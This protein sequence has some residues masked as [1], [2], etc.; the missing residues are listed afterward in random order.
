M[1]FVDVADKVDA[2]IPAISDAFK[3]PKKS[4]LSQSIFYEIYLLD[5]LTNYP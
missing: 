3:R 4:N 1:E 5:R 2:I